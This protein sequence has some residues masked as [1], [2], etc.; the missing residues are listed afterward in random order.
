[1]ALVTAALGS[2]GKEA[3]PMRM[4]SEKRLEVGEGRYKNNSSS[5]CQIKR[6]AVM[7]WSLLIFNPFLQCKF[8]KFRDLVLYP[9]LVAQSPKF[10]YANIC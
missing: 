8:P 4:A 3:S 1:M 5:P 2:L 7:Q 9:K 10:R 6:M